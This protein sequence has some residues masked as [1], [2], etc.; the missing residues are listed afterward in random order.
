MNQVIDYLKKYSSADH[1]ISG[2]AIAS[3]FGITGVKVREYINQARRNSVPI[4]SK[5]W[6]YYYSENPDDVRKTVR[7]L[8]DRISATEGAINGLTAL[9][10]V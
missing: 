7:S 10:T 2:G 9:Y 6:G 4:C 5:R 8:R 1:P 3:H